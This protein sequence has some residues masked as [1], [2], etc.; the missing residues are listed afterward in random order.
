MTPFFNI[1]FPFDAGFD[2]VS[3]FFA[4]YRIRWY[5]NVEVTRRVKRITN[6]ILLNKE[7]NQVLLLNK[8][9]RGWW[10]A[11]GGKM[12]LGEHVVQ[13]VQREFKEET[14]LKILNPLLRGVFN[15]VMMDN[16]ELIEEW[17]LFTF[18]SQSYTGQ[19][20]SHSPE[21]DLHWIDV[22]SIA[23]LPKAE[24][25]QLYFD[26]ILTKESLLAMTFYYSRDY[27]LISYRQ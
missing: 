14:G 26:H 5:A 21:G 18:L 23:S 27:Q 3:F 20:M 11:P 22:S 6:C 25:D 4:S 2:P 16:G 24:G 15:I 13:S 12:E 9:K 19:L 10:V 7:A 17:M 8:P 1:D